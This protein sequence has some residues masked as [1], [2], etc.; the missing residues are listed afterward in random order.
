MTGEFYIM[1]P[2]KS[3]INTEFLEFNDNTVRILQDGRYGITDHH[4]SWSIT[5]YKDLKKGTFVV[6]NAFRDIEYCG[7]II[8][9]GGE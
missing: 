4:T 6:L 5:N 2:K 8:L 9:C 7:P 1:Y 3:R